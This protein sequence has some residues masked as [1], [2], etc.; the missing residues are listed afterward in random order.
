MLPQRVSLFFV[1]FLL[2][3]TANAATQSGQK[4]VAA[5]SSLSATQ[6]VLWLA[7]EAG[8]FQRHALDVELVYIGTGTKM[9]QAIVGGDIKIGQVGGAAPLAARLRGAD[10][11][12]IAVAYNTLALSLMTQTDIRS[13]A[14][15]KG[16][17]LGISRFG[18]NTDFGM[19][20]LLRKHNIAERDVTFLQFGE[21]QAIF[22]ALQ[23]GAIHAGIL[24]YPTTAAAIK[25]G[26]KE[27]VDLS[28][29]GIE[30]PNSNVVVTDRF[31]QN[32]SDLVR[33]FVMG[34]VEGIHRYKTDSLFTKRVMSKYLRVQDQ[35][36]LDETYRLF[37]PK[38][39][40]IPYPTVG[41]FRMA[42]ESLS[43]EPRAKTVKPEEFYDDSILR[44]LERAG[45]FQQLYRQ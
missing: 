15:L 19:R 7:K 43:D 16:K 34:Y 5:Y 24:S 27:L 14:D 28:D 11:K 42:L 33:R 13:M 22:G 23:S 1:F 35:Q 8:A 3:Y 45:F 30:F 31:L 9:I 39:P 41:G 29:T 26:F 18:S 44:N 12:I 17:R 20:F 4:L 38:I 21:A 6:A 40:R 25:K 10:V 36:V 32:Q 37:A 2:T